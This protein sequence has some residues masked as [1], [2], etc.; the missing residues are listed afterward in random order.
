VLLSGKQQRAKCRRR[1]LWRNSKTKFVEKE[2]KETFDNSVVE[3][4]QEFD[5]LEF[6][7]RLHMGKNPCCEG[8][9]VGATFGTIWGL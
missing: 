3:E 8:V 5:C 1:L 2:S 9:V 7:A 4:P 6:A